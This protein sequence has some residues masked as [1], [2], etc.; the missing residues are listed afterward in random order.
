VQ[1]HG[2]ERLTRGQRPHARER[3][4]LPTPVA[5]EAMAA[6]RSTDGRGALA[7]GHDA[8]I[9]MPHR[10]LSDSRRCADYG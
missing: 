7:A 5:T 10:S 4:L 3:G 6:Q 9:A 8:T 1:F 2:A